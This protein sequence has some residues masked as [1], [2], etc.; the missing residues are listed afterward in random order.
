MITGKICP[1]YDQIARYYEL[2]HADL[3]EDIP[4]L[5]N[6]AKESGT[7]VLELGCGTG[8]LL[9]PLAKV[10]SFVHG[11]DSSAVMLALA[12]QR[13]Q[14]L[15]VNVADRVALT[16]SDM[17]QLNLQ[18][19]ADTF[20]LALISYNTFLHLDT[21][22]ATQTLKQLHPYL[23]TNGRLL[24]D[25]INPFHIANTPD[26]PTLLLEK[27]AVDPETDEIVLQFASNQLN[28][29]DQIL[30]ITWVF[31]ASPAAGG[32]VKRTVAVMPY[33]YRFPH[34]LQLLLQETGYHLTAQ[35]GDYDQSPFREEAPRL[36][37]L[38]S[39]T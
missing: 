1:M 17:G 6:L 35:W 26:D 23:K 22:V 29:A 20:D 37:I 36:L 13:L 15:P 32:A 10:C 38:A 11:V 3:V 9:L 2:F 16:Q 19:A 12:R 39:P 30:N 31:D 18:G 14:T 21:A 8:R 25:L 4:F 28:S 33:Y 7:H 5:Q 24:I 34:Q 27:T